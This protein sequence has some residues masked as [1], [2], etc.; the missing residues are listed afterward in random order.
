MIPIGVYLLLMAALVVASLGRVRRSLSISLGRDFVSEPMSGLT[1]AETV[2]LTRWGADLE[3]AGF[4]PAG[5]YRT[6]PHAPPEDGSER[7]SR[8]RFW[9]PEDRRAA[10]CATLMVMVVKV[11]ETATETRSLQL[12]IVSRTADRV[13]ETVWM[14][15]R[16]PVPSDP[17][18]SVVRFPVPDARAMAEAHRARAAEPLVEIADPPAALQ[19]LLRREIE[20]QIDGGWLL[21]KGGNAVGTAKYTKAAMA[22]ALNPLTGEPR[23]PLV[24]A[25]LLVALATAGVVG[26]WLADQIAPGWPAAAVWM[27]MLWISA[28]LAFPNTAIVASPLIATSAAALHPTA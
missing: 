13:Y 3:A 8:L 4:R 6:V 25:M 1:P 10:A 7:V 2:R 5:D 12:S 16:T 23:R 17:R 14:P 28:D 21:I 9:A 22:L 15:S 18:D 20:R 11:G 26:A 19:E 24:N 27:T